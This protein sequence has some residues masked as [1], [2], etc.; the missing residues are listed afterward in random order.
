MI[1]R[2]L[3]IVSESEIQAVETLVEW[4]EAF[5]EQEENEDNEDNEEEVEVPNRVDQIVKNK[6]SLMSVK[7]VQG[8][9]IQKLNTKKG[10]VYQLWTPYNRPNPVWAQGPAQHELNRTECITFLADLWV[11]DARDWLIDI[12]RE[13]ARSI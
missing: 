2:R 11:A 12:R 9:W 5:K 3:P 10:K 7:N 1:S 8:W 4:L 6:I 13:I